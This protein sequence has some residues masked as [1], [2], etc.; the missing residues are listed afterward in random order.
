M[1]RAALAVAILASACAAYPGSPRS[2]I[3]TICAF[4][5]RRSAS[6]SSAS[7]A[8]SGAGIRRVIFFSSMAAR[9][10]HIDT[11]VQLTVR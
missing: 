9:L 10:R 11:T 5:L 6:A 3:R 4:R 7:R 1:A 2:S 8:C